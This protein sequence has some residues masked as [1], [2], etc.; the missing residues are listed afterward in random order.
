MLNFLFWMGVM[1]MMMPR[2]HLVKMYN[3]MIS[4]VLPDVT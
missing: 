2:R 3:N 1:E 4:H